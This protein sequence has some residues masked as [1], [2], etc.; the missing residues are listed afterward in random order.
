M[1]FDPSSRVNYTSQYAGQGV[2]QLEF[3]ALDAQ[4]YAVHVLLNGADVNGSAFIVAIYA[5]I[6]IFA[7][8]SL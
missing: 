8:N 3:I 2:F 1:T 4:E 6:S 5:C 7:K